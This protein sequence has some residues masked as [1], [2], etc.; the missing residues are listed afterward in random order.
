MLRNAIEH[1]LLLEAQRASDPNPADKETGVSVNARLLN[2][3]PGFAA[4]NHNVYF[5][6]DSADVSAATLNN[7]RGTL[8]SVGQDEAV[9]D[10]RP[11]EHSTTY[12]WRIDEVKADGTVTKG[13]VWRF[14]T[15][16]SG[17]V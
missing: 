5:G 4:Q 16:P 8:Y 12:Y 10:P 11:L 13:R 2:W 7:T 3:I 1:M 14:T 15:E 9:F 6:T 17:S